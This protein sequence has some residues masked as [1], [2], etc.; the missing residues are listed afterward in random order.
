MKIH[1]AKFDSIPSTNEEALR[2]ASAGVHEGYCVVAD[3]QTAGKGR[4]GRTW[5]SSKGEGLYFSIVLRPA[6]ETRIVPVLTLLTAVA[7]HETIVE[8][9]GVEADIKWP[10]DIHVGGRKLAGILAEGCETN[11]GLAVIVGIGINLSTR[12]LPEVVRASAT[13]ISDE[14]GKT[15]AAADIVP[16]LV[17]NLSARYG[18]FNQSPAVQS[19]LDDWCER[20]SYAIGRNVNVITRT[21]SFTGVTAGLDRFGSLLV[22]SD[23]GQIRTVTA[24]DVESVRSVKCE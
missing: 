12:N 9:C 3:E 19:V 23:N 21:G 13:S 24:G 11:K 20:S 4:E 17:K 5:I 7:V 2:Q 18:R 15:P 14:T 1:I 16:L 22:K 8:F 6:L 10:N